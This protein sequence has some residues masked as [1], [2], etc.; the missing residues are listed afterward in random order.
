M[1]IA[2]PLF[3][4]TLALVAGGCSD[5]STANMSP[6][7]AQMQKAC[8]GGNLNACSALMQND[9]AKDETRAKMTTSGNGTHPATAGN[10]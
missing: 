9:R 5:K 6:A 2:L 3:A 4:M 8:N 1:K 7:E 10:F